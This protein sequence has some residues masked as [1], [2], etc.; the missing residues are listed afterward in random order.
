MLKKPVSVDARA[1]L[2][3]PLGR[4]LQA[5]NPRWWRRRRIVEV[6][7]ALLSLMQDLQS[8]RGL[9]CAV[10][11]RQSEFDEE[12]SA[13]SG[14]LQRSLRAFSEQFGERQALFRGESWDQLLARWESLRCNWPGLD[15]H[16]NLTVHSELVLMAV[17][18]IRHIGQDNV[19]S[20][21]PACVR[22]LGEW[23]TMVEHLG[24]LR[25]IGMHRLGHPG[26][27]MELRLAALYRVH[28][29]EARST[30]ASVADEF[31]APALLEAG[32]RVVELAADLRAGLPKGVDARGYH[33]EMTAVIDAWCAQTR[34]RLS[35][36]ADA[37]FS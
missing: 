16:T 18:I 20:L 15:F 17:G 36:F 30:L 32:G 4:S 22:V 19:R 5:C 35:A 7:I 21:Q 11:G 28:L 37:N 14:R 31:N 9:S 3:V 6:S 25:A 24:L 10:L 13:V 29:H 23:P 26:E 12:L 34:Q 33:A 8:H 27:P 2:I 1:A